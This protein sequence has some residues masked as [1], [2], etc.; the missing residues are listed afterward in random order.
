[1]ART[2][3]EPRPELSVVHVGKFDEF[4]DATYPLLLKI[5]MAVGATFY[6]AE[7]V[8]DETMTYLYQ[9]W[10][11]IIEPRA[12]ARRAVITNVAKVKKRDRQRFDRTVA[13]GHITLETDDGTALT[14]W[15]D[16]EWVTQRL[17]ALPPA[18]REVMAGLFDD[19]SISEIAEALGKTEATI[20]KNLQWARDRLRA[21]IALER[22]GNQPCR[23][24]ADTPTTREE[25]R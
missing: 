13:G 25:T 15:E 1:V 12:Y 8:V 5:A 2:P 20:R 11:K 3:P 10:G 4:F 9:R 6:E 23:G 7:E 16:R 17:A 22:E 21:D 19:M 18:Q 24:R 14:A